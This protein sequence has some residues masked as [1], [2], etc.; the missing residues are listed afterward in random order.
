MDKE[1][2]N[3][4]E[5]SYIAPCGIYCGACD[6]YLGKSKE[7]AK[8]L[9]RILDGFNILD[10]APVVL[11]TDQ[12]KIKSFMKILKK[13]SKG[14]NCKGCNGGG[15]NPMCPIIKCT[16]QK[17]FLTCTEC[18]NFPC[19]PS[20]EDGKM[21]LMNKAGMLEL[22]SKRYGYWNI[23]NLKRIKEIGYKKFI[24]EMQEKVKKG[25]LTSD[26]I[27]KEMLFSKFVQQIE[28]SEK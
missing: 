8:E 28:N 17:N 12:N 20:E 23:E 13:W 1:N 2:L 16:K 5:Q 3:K 6:A 25:F 14:I 18:E 9:H 24:E 10:V 7:L 21:P 22:I 27:T 15:G 19:Q 11:G 4:K 26:V